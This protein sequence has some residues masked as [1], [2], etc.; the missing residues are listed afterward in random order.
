[1]VRTLFAPVFV[2]TLAAT[3]LTAQDTARVAATGEKSPMTARVIGIVPGAGHIYAGET[4]RGLGYLAATAGIIV[5]GGTLLAAECVGSLGES[6]ENSNTDDVATVAALGV[7][8]W[9]IYDA[10]RAAH[11]TNARRRLRTSLIVAPVTLTSTR[12][13]DRRVL[14]LGLSLATR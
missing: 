6:C 11:R 5:I 12:G 8:A 7:W 14:K 2:L 1:M 13:A 3:T 9:S 10:G 4:M